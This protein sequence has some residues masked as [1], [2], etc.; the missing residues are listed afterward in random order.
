M[1]ARA[2]VRREIGRPPPAAAHRGRASE[3]GRQRARWAGAG[4]PHFRGGRLAARP[5]GTQEGSGGQPEPS[6]AGLWINK[7]PLLTFLRFLAAQGEGL[8]EGMLRIG[9]QVGPLPDA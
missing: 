7:Q 9:Q 6:L 8:R 1:A 2:G 4:D 3:P 5:L